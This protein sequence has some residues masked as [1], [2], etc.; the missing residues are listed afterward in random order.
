MS[1]NKRQS[2][3]SGGSPFGGPGSGRGRGGPGGRMMPGEKAKDLKGSL[4]KLVKKLK[5]QWLSIFIVCV[6]AVLSTIFNTIGPKISGLATTEI[7]R[8]F[9]ASIAGTGG[10]DFDYILNVIITLLILYVISAIMRYLQSFIMTGVTNKVTYGLRKDISEKI[11]R[12]PLGYFDRVQSGEVLSR[13]TNDV[14]TVSGNLNQSI[15][16]V[17]TSV[18]T[19]IGVVIMMLTISP[20]MTLIAFATL[21][22][23]LIITK[24][25]VKLSQPHFIGRQKYLG[26]A[27]GHVEE[28]FSGHVVVKAFNRED[29]SQA[30]FEEILDNLYEANWKSQFYS[31]I[32]MPLTKLL[33]NIGYVLICIVGSALT[34]AG[35]IGLGDIQ[36]FTQYMRNFTQPIQQIANISNVLQST[37][38]A[39]ERVFE[40][41]DEEE[42]VRD[43]ADSYDLVNKDYF[44]NIKG[45]ITFDHVNFGYLPGQTIINDFSIKVEPGKMVAIVGP[46]GAGKTTIVKLL[47]R[48]YDVNSGAIKVDGV[49]IRDFTRNGLRDM[50]GMVLQ[51]TWLYNGTIADN[52]RYGRLDA[53]DEDVKNAAKAAQVHHFVKTLPDGYNMILGEDATNISQGQKQLLTIARAILSDPK[54]LILDEATSSVDTRTEILIQKAMANLMKGRTSFVIAHR[55]STIRDADMILVMRDGDIVEVGNHDELIAKGGFYK[56]LYQSQFEHPTVAD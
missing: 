11:N 54:I 50:F 27:N 17:I 10:I 31:G 45:E 19:L 52:I 36:A 4:K 3:P 22:F 8:G 9:A 1:E 42:E 15:V 18:T 49:D 38:A 40:F 51:D 20:I 29:E 24:N 34:I 55:L 39:A 7:A 5:G 30:Q 12:M 47:M 6:C 35:K 21:P 48:Y 41:L 43:K 2:Q 33:G 23:T 53:T 14:E 46:T 32:M 44:D 56:D 37:A 16:Q 28:M 25:V 26:Q 13:I